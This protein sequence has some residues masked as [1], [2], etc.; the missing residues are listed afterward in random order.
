MG[1]EVEAIAQRKE[2]RADDG[3]AR[4]K[5]RQVYYLDV[6]GAANAAA[7]S[8]V[9]FTAEER[10]GETYVVTVQFTHPL[11]LERADYLGKAA[12][13]RI[14]HGDPIDGAAPRQFAG[15]I[16]RLSRLQRSRDLFSYEA[17]VEPLAAR[18]KLTQASRIYQHQTAPQIIEAI[19][20]RHDLQG[21][22]FAFR[23]RRKYPQH[24]FRF[25]YQ[26]SD[27]AYI[28]LLMEQ[29]GLYSYFVPGKFGEMLV[30]GDDIDHYLY[31][32][33]LRVPY[34]ETA[35]LEAGVEAVLALQSHA[36]T[37]AASFRVA[38]Y[39]PGSA[40]ERFTGEANVARK[41]TTTY[42]QS[43]VFGTHHLDFEGG[44]WEAQLRHEAAMAG[45]LVFSG[46]SN[47][48][49]LRPARILRMDLALAEAPNGQVIT[50]VIHTGARDAAYRNTF[51][52]IP[53]DRR[54]RL[55]LAED[56]WPRIQGTLSARVTSPG[57][58]KYAY[59]TQQGHYTVRF[60]L[61]FDT[62]PNG[63]ESVPLALAKPF[64]GARQTGFH[65]PL[66][67]GTYVDVAFRDGNPNKPYIA[68]VQH[69]SQH[70]DLIT[71]RDRWLSRNVIRTQSNNK[72]RFEDWEGQ[73]GV[74]LSTDFARKSQL[75][76]GYLVD[77]KRQKRGEG[78]E[79]RTSG[80]GAIRGGKGLFL[81]AD[82][83]PSAKGP[84]LGMDAARGLLQQA[85][86]QAEAL[87]SA[88]QA[89]QAVAADYGRQKALLDN[90]LDTLKQAGLLAS[91][92]A[93]MALASGGDL[94]LSASQNLIG[95]SG[96][97]A[98]FSALKRFTV[99]AGELVSIFAQKLGIKLFAARGPIDIQAQ[100]DD[101][102]LLADRNVTIS[103][104]NGRVV[105]EAEKELLLKCGGSFLRLSLTG[106]ED[107][108]RGD[109]IIR[110]AS[111]QQTTKQSLS[112]AMNTWKHAEFDEAFTVRWPFDDEPASHES[113]AVLRDDGSRIRG[114]ADA[115]GK[116]SLQK[117]LFAESVDLLC[118]L[119]S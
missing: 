92:P 47:V 45:Q 73:E 117:S 24:A 14:D 48:L 118:A 30:F 6:P 13:F 3:D 86:S 50:E 115:E 44:K 5:R 66:V 18:L 19:L 2:Y 64:A 111:Y 57:Q 32:P 114:A 107:G 61:D 52:A 43:Y 1:K 25:Q 41:E 72:L 12:T 40:W 81:S 94:Q 17:V 62:W 106:I 108:T 102:R 15:C 31:Q 105:I 7:L 42:G 71:N 79:L 98:D 70:E 99:A 91:A 58:Y 34:R 93:G 39:H 69:N 49:D 77:D 96:G 119:K 60:D 83:Q 65:F 35:G 88:A 56:R 113:Y 23:L 109:R 63:G 37:V 82:D 55:P 103:S 110:S 11:E 95:T 89:A 46:E 4:L 78:F 9:S 59:L 36:T 90:T 85:L 27:W 10:L 84:Q 21:H 101:M 87:A 104:A 68:H 75:N 97:H 8:V 53:S 67:D 16:T 80:W 29:E 76:L 51:K 38:D 33:E 100:S 22:Q 20:R 112:Q 54:F 26:M 74:K 28:R 116:T